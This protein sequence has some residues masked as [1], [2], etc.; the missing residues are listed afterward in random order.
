MNNNHQT[1]QNNFF[2]TS[3]N[4]NNNKNILYNSN[5]LSSNNFML[6]QKRSRFMST[7]DITS[8]IEM[9]PIQNSHPRFFQYIPSSSSSTF[10]KKMSID[11][12]DDNFNNKNIQIIGC[13]CKNSGCLK[14]YCE[15]F[16]RMKFCDANCQCKNCFNT[17]EH[18]KERNESIQIYLMKSP[19]S[20]KKNNLNINNVT[21]S[22]KKSNCLKK[23][24]ECYQIGIKCNNNCKC[25][26]C[27]NRNKGD[28]KMFEVN[29]IEN[30]NN[31]KKRE[32]YFSFD[33]IS[34]FNRN[35]KDGLF[36]N[37]FN[38]NNQIIS[39]KTVEIDTKKVIIDNYNFLNNNNINN[40]INI[41]NENNTILNNNDNNNRTSAFNTM[42]VND[43]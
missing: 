20:F 38:N 17:I 15:C 39:L 36:Y 26:E 43:N 34:F 31:N 22:C 11:L 16:T 10:S 8:D 12:T 29:N 32:R 23:Y 27:K 2:I 41:V 33:E 4:N 14:R 35:E 28:K 1:A 6:E 25:F 3:N 42:K 37:H 24:C 5:N 13:N 30:N 9:K 40:N 18:E 21:C 7:D 19:I